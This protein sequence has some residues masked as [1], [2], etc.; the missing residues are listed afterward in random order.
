MIAFFR[1]YWRYMS[2]LNN[3]ER[4]IWLAIMCLMTMSIIGIN[5]LFFANSTIGIIVAL[6]TILIIS[7]PIRMSTI[8][9]SSRNNKN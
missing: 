9:P 4:F 5:S 3:P 7:V 8:S 6:L 2:G 1:S